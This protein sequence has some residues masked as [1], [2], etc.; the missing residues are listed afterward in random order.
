MWI[1]VMLQ[2][3]SR[4]GVTESIVNFAEFMKYGE[5]FEKKVQVVL[6]GIFV[7][8]WKQGRLESWRGACGVEP[9]SLIRCQWSKRPLPP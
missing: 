5:K 1:V 7:A 8:K 9:Y 6:R 2:T 4:G 3:S